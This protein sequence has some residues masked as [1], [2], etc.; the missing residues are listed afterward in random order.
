LIDVDL[1]LFGSKVDI[2]TLK[3]LIK[4]GIS[5][6]S[7]KEFEFEAKNFDQFELQEEFKEKREIDLEKVGF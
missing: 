2:G 5:V 1:G 3:S 4:G 7:P 6:T